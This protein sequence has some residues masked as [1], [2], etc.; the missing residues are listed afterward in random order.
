MLQQKVN[1]GTVEVKKISRAENLA[2]VGTQYHK[3]EEVGYHMR[4]TGQTIVHERHS[5]MP[6]LD[7]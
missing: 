4:S 7:G 5:I 2:D 1:D 3:A 6:T